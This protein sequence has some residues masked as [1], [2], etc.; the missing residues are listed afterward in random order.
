MSDENTTGPDTPASSGLGARL[1]DKASELKDQ[2]TS[3]AQDLKDQAAA[4]ASGVKEQV[5]AKAG[6]LKDASFT[7]A[8][9]A[10]DEFNAALPIIREAGYTLSSVDLHIGM[11]PKLVAA[12]APRG[13]VSA[14]EIERLVAAHADKPLLVLLM[15][16]LYQAWKLQTRIKIVGLKPIGLSV[17]LGIVPAVAIKFA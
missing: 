16:S 14:E 6:E 13:D 2:A 7:K 8:A 11:P 1:L 15:K 3:K 12:F 4:A 9:E 10:V 17:E 5:A